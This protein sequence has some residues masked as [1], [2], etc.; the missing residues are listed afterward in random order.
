VCAVGL[1]Q[2]LHDASVHGATAGAQL[3]RGGAVQV[4][5]PWTPPGSVTLTSL[6][7]R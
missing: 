7:F 3:L 6:S 1:L 4:W 2:P 5:L